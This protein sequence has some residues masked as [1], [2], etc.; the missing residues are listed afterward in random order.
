VVE[1][2]GTAFFVETKLYDGFDEKA[3]FQGCADV[4]CKVARA[5][6]VVRGKTASDVAWSRE[7]PLAQAFKSGRASVTERALMLKKL[8]EDGGVDVWLA[9]GTDKASR[10]RTPTFPLWSQFDHLF[11][12]LPA[13]PGLDAP[14]T[15]DPHCEHC[16]PGTLTAR[17][18]GIP[19]YVFKTRAVLGGVET[20]GRWTTAWAAAPEPP[21]RL[22]VTHRAQV[23]PDGALTDAVSYEATGTEAVDQSRSPP[24]GE[25]VQ[26]EALDAARRLSPVAR[27]S[28]ARF[29][30]CVAVEATCRWSSTRTLPMMAVADGARWLVT[31]ALLDP[32]SDTLFDEAERKQDVHFTWDDFT[33]E[34]VLDVEAPPGFRLAG[35]PPP[36]TVACD[37]MSATVKVEAT[38]RGARLTRSLTRNVGEWPKA[39]YPDLRKVAAAFK[40]A[41]HQLLVFE[42]R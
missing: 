13:Q 24:L 31:T 35:A 30:P 7:E 38:D 26:R 5:Q 39:L 1:P 19:I 42:K 37:A 32:Y 41:R 29:G 17:H 4:A 14:M 11:V 20:E 2:R 21:S 3:D 12:Y 25:K 16:A 9:Y 10:Q 8:L 15:I 18:R 28:E 6:A 33:W 27:V 40:Q 23:Q 22:R 34:E 36:V